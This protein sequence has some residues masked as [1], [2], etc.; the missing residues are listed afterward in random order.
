LLLVVGTSLG[1]Y[2]AAGLV[3][4]SVA[5]GAKVVIVNE[6]PTPYDDIAEVVVRESISRSLPTIVGVPREPS[7]HEGRVDLC[8]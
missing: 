3:P 8:G 4:L 1:V 2:P 7:N 5:H 6:Q